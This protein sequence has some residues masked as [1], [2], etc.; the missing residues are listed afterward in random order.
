MYIELWINKRTCV[1]D[2]TTRVLL[3]LNK[4]QCL[5]YTFNK[6]NGLMGWCRK[7]EPILYSYLWPT[8]IQHT[9]CRRL[10]LIGLSLRKICQFGLMAWWQFYRQLCGLLQ[11]L[12]TFRLLKASFIDYSH[13]I[14]WNQTVLT[15]KIWFCRGW[16]LSILQCKSSIQDWPHHH[17][18]SHYNPQQKYIERRWHPWLYN[19]RI[20]NLWTQ[21][22]CIV[23][24]LSQFF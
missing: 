13:E 19:V 7:R 3:D 9:S 8:G 1:H 10:F 4:F 17:W 16:E 24:N 12:T 23:G 2:I 6:D 18:A 14:S 15:C 5:L 22:S 21:K 11:D 20:L